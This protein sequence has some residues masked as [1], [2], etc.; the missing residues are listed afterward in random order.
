LEIATAPAELFRH[1]QP[2]VNWR[3]FLAFVKE[4]HG[5]N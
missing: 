4:K 5:L 3:Y 1:R 2:A